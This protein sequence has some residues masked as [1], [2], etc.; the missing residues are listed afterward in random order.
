MSPL[1]SCL[2]P[3]AALLLAACTSAGTR[4]AGTANMSDACGSGETLVCEVPNTGRIKHG[5][6]TKGSK[7][8]ACQRSGETGPPIIPPVP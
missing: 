7:R 3:V 4:D 8:C 5:S 2:L 1:K 6:F